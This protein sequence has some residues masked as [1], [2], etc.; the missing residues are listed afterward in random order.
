MSAPAASS[1]PP[2]R[3]SAA[4]EPVPSLQELAAE[5]KRLRCEV[6][7]LKKEKVSWD[8]RHMLSMSG[9]SAVI[10]PVPVTA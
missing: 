4:A 10:V 1:S 9:Q 2:V 5:V 3:D 6:E 8:E 7:Q